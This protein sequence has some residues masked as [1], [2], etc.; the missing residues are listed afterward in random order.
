MVTF[1]GCA[2]TAILF[3]MQNG[4]TSTR[5]LQVVSWNCQSLVATSRLEEIL[6]HY[7]NKDIIMLQGTRLAQHEYPINEFVVRN[8]TVVSHGYG[9]S[10]NKHGGVTTCLN[11]RTVPRTALAGIAWR[12]N[13]RR[14]TFK[15]CEAA[16]QDANDAC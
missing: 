11:L 9:P 12:A 8:F 15:R 10:S 5:K 1:L 16:L 6:D 7:R 2:I 13:G 14:L 4:T 3:I